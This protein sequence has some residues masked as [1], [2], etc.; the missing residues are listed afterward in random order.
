[1]DM[2]YEFERLAGVV[3]ER[4]KCEPRTRA[5]FV[6]FGKRRHT[7]KILTWDGTGVVLVYKKLDR[8]VFEIPLPGPDGASTV[9]ISETTLDSIFAGIHTHGS[10]K[11]VKR[12]VH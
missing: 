6:F 4:M 10:T 11:I 5:L 7:V 8:G 3:R 2:R 12:I 9:S 1:V